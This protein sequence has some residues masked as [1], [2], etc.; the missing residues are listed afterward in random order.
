[1]RW[2]SSEGLERFAG[3]WYG[4]VKGSCNRGEGAGAWD[5][6]RLSPHRAPS[7]PCPV[8]RASMDPTAPRNVVVIMVASATG[9][10]GSV[11]VLLA[12]LGMGE[13]HC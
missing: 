11:A 1:M 3:S 7:A 10:L 5:S 8:R 4:S 9:S 2:V 12:T 6:V 13:W